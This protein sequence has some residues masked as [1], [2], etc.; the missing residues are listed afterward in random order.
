MIVKKLTINEQIFLIA[1]LHLKDDAYGVKIQKKIR[2][3][4]GTSLLF[5]TLYNTLENLVR[6]GYVSTKKGEPTAQRGGNNKIYYSLTD[7]GI[8]A[9]QK[10]HEL[11]QSLWKDLPGLI[12]EEN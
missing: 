3:L 12:V 9:L 10:A 2:E 8:L 4:T 7:E 1:I 5:G 11:Q 6:K